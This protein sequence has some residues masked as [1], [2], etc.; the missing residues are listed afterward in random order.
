MKYAKIV[1]FGGELIEAADADYSDYKGFLVCPECGEPVFL[2]NSFHRGATEVRSMFVHYRAIP[3]VSACELRVGKYTLTDVA[4]SQAIARGQRLQG[5]KISLWKYLKQSLTINLKSWS[6]FVKDAKNDEILGDIVDYGMEILFLNQDFIINNTLPR[7]AEI[8]ISGDKRLEILP[9]KKGQIKKFLQ[10][11]RSTWSFH[12][13]I[14]EEAL[15]LF[16]DSET[17]KEIRF[18]LLCCLCHP[19]SLKMMPELL[20]L[21][22]S[23]QEWKQIFMAYLTLQV[24]FIFL[25]VDWIAIW[26][27]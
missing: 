6:Q 2:R 5:L 7:T 16:L 3:E 20:D 22:M 15:K 19:K 21:E 1:K 10:S 13:K 27:E 18:R 11:R 26:S 9:H 24:T 12:T 23:S 17:M 25:S 8:L 14:T 4:A